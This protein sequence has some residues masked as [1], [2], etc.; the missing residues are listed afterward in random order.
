MYWENRE[1]HFPVEEYEG[2]FFCQFLRRAVL[3]PFPF[4]G[5]RVRA[6]AEAGNISF[7]LLIPVNRLAGNPEKLREIGAEKLLLFLIRGRRL[8][9]VPATGAVTLRQGLQ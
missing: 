3:F 9:A 8:R 6:N 4:C 2:L 7:A 5:M 1:A